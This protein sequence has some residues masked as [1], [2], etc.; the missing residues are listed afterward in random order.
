MSIGSKKKNK[1][2]FAVLAAITVGVLLFAVA[3]EVSKANEEK[4]KY[5]SASERL[6][7]LDF[8]DAVNEMERAAES[9]DIAGVN[10]AAGKAEAYLS[11]SGLEDCGVVYKVI[12][13]ICEGEYDGAACAELSEAVRKAIGGDGGAALRSLSDSEKIIPE[14]GEETTEDLLSSRVLERLGR[15]RDDVA[16]GRAVAFACPNAVFRECDSD[17]ENVFKYSGANIFISIGGESARVRMYCFDRDIDERY[18]ISKEEAERTADMVIK[19]EKL[20]IS[21]NAQTELADGIYRILYFGE[22]DLSDTA[23]VTVEIYSDTGRLRKY[24]AVN[25][26]SNSR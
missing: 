18:S 13:E 14:T 21:E 23:L 6:A 7:L 1:T 24:D 8:A 12:G 3:L 11:R 17:E 15:G 5:I 4:E 20:K 16:Y 9:G 22:G 2:L 19:K 25:Y 10:R 26:Y